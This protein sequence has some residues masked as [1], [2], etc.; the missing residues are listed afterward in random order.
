MTI[1]S[2]EEVKKF[3][4]TDDEIHAIFS[5]R[6]PAVGDKVKYPDAWDD[7]YHDANVLKVFYFQGEYYV[8]LDV[9]SFD[10]G[11]FKEV[12]EKT[13]SSEGDGW[14][15]HQLDNLN[16]EFEETLNVVTASR[17]ANNL[18]CRIYGLKRLKNQHKIDFLRISLDDFSQKLSELRK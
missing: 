12:N 6:L 11:F 18:S 5:D 14:I 4:L 9:V 7:F 10:T 17:L 2:F 15:Y 16:G 3:H 8:V 1:L 13:H